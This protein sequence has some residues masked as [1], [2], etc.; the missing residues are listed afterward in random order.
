MASQ[1]FAGAIVEHRV[2]HIEQS[3]EFRF[4]R[5]F[6]HQLTQRRHLCRLARFDTSTRNRPLTLFGRCSAP[7]QQDFIPA[8]ADHTH[9]GCGA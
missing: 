6:F 8:N 3:D 5:R 9:C 4:N 2:D 7:D 1:Q